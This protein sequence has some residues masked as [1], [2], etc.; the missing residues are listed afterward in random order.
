M[1]NMGKR[2]RRTRRKEK[3]SRPKKRGMMSFATLLKSDSTKMTIVYALPLN[4]NDSYYLM[5]DVLDNY[6][7]NEQPRIDR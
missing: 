5:L 6:N 2:I 3:R 1:Y 4:V 7:K